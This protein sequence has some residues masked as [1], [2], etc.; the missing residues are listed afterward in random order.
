MQKAKGPDFLAVGLEKSGNHWT[1]AIL[2]AHPDIVCFPIMPFVKE[3]GELNRENVGELHLFNGLASMEPGTED[4]FTRPMEYFADRY[5]KLFADL[6]P[7]IGKIPKAELYQKFI[8]RYNEIC[9]SER[10][11]KKMVGE[12][13][14]A[15]VFHLDFID[16]FYPNIKKLCVIRNPKDRIVSWHYHQIRRG[17]IEFSR[18]VDDQF[19]IVY[20]K[21]RIQK[22]YQALLNYTGN[23]SCFTYEG[24]IND[25]NETVKGVLKYLEVPFD[26]AVLKTMNEESSFKKLNAKDSGSEGRDAGEESVMSHF[27]KG[28]AGDWKNHL[29]E[30]QANLVDELTG[31]LEQKVFKKYNIHQSHN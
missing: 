10:R 19:I 31:E 27:R 3:S 8:E 5:N 1:A 2:S 30:S 26:D 28:I 11:G 17:R 25:F 9:D 15:Y 21:T 4:K 12:A 22:E 18:K 23:L 7:Y 6:V 24:L 20:C 29:T 14:P 13:T 16:T